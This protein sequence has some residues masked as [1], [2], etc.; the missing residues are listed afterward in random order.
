MPACRALVYWRRKAAS[1]AAL[2]RAETDPLAVVRHPRMAL[3]RND[4]FAT[5]HCVSLTH[6]HNM[7]RQCC[8]SCGNLSRLKAFEH[9]VCLH[10]HTAALFL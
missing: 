6:A 5:M 4:A 2:H 10:R 1:R 3:T 7:V 8:T 9:V